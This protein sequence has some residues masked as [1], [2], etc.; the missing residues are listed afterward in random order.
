M[1]TKNRKATF[2]EEQQTLK[3]IGAKLEVDKEIEALL[4]KELPELLKEAYKENL[5]KEQEIEIIKETIKKRQIELISTY[6][7]DIMKHIIT[8]NDKKHI[9]DLVNWYLKDYEFLS[10][11]EAR[12]IDYIEKNYKPNNKEV[13]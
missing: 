6:N 3:R 9:H 4:K 8:D 11:V 5:S 1:E 12:M 7:F 13:S 10:N 2:N